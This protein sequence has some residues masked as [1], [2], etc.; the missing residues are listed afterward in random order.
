VPSIT[1]SIGICIFPYKHC[2]PVDV[3]R[4]ADQ[5]MYEIKRGIKAGVAFAGSYEASDSPA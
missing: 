5:A 3:V 2:T 1:A 4:R